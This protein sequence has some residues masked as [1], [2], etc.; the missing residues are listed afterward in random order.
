MGAFMNAGKVP[1]AYLVLCVFVLVAMIM[2]GILARK[3][4]YDS[5]KAAKARGE[6]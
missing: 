2:M 5:E 3:P 4:A 1:A 6:I